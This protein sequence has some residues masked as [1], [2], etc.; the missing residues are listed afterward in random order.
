MVVCTIYVPDGVDDAVC[1]S[2]SFKS[3][4]SN[5]AFAIVVGRGREAS[6]SRHWARLKLGV[7]VVG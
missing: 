5:A 2:A 6:S 7:V 4:L 1:R 3:V